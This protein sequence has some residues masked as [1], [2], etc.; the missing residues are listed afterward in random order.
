MRI[1]LQRVSSASVTVAEEVVGEI[2]RGLLVFVGIGHGDTEEHAE[3]LVEKAINLR[4]FED[5]AGK[6]NLSVRDTGGGLLIVSQ[7]T[8]YADIRRG[9]RPSFDN[10]AHPEVA[11]KLYEYFVNQ[12]RIRVTNVATGVFQADMMVRLANDGPVTVF[13]DSVDKFGNKSKPVK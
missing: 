6:M 7:F 11:K 12:A 5:A 2:G 1:L 13:H 4:L 10:A 9:R 8:L 3:Y